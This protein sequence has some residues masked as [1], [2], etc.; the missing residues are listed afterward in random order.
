MYLYLGALLLIL[1]FAQDFFYIKWP[2]L[3]KQQ[4]DLMYKQWSGLVLM[5]YVIAQWYLSMLRVLGQGRIAKYNYEIH[6]QL[7]VLAPLFFYAHS[8]KL[9]YAYL[10]WLSSVYFANVVVG[11]LNQEVIPA[12]K[13]WFSYYWMILHVTLA[14]LITI[15]MVY[16]V[17]ISFYYQ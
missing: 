15:L 2:W 10:F 11:L 17:F 4:M 5:I 14:V 12:R 8:A 16:H 3:V 13:K 6:K 9:G 1:F 7:G